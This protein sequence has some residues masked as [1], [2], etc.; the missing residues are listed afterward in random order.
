MLC[1]KLYLFRSTNATM[2][3][4]R[5]RAGAGRSVL[6]LSAIRG[7][8]STKTR[9]ALPCASANLPS[10][11]PPRRRRRCDSRTSSLTRSPNHPAAIA[12]SRDTTHARSASV[13]R[14]A[15]N[16]L[17]AAPAAT[18]MCRA[19]GSPP[20]S[21][22]PSVSA[23]VAVDVDDVRGVD[24]DHAVVGHHREQPA[25]RQILRRPTPPAGRPGAA[26][27]A[28]AVDPGPYR[29]PIMSSSLW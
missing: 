8:R 25:R 15:A 4:I 1:H 16:T 13:S 26:A 9:V 17:S 22:T 24:G 2:L 23:S 20:M 28:T 10:R 7:G 18:Y 19:R 11:G 12:S 5:R 29:C 27:S 3:L 14:H 21:V 6:R